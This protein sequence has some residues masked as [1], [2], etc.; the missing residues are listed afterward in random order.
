MPVYARL[1]KS[2]KGVWTDSASTNV[3]SNVASP[4]VASPAVL[5]RRKCWNA[6][7][8]L[9][10][11]SPRADGAKWVED[12]GGGQ[13]RHVRIHVIAFVASHLFNCGVEQFRD[14]EVALMRQVH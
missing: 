12:V 3:A 7:N 2:R 5:A 9:S 14:N 11:F 8:S 4:D 10:H 1:T 6:N 13:R